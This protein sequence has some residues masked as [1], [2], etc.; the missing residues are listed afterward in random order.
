MNA[1]RA[2]VVGVGMIGSLHARIYAEDPRTSLAAVVDPDEERARRV[3]EPLGATWYS[4]TETMLARETVDLVSIAT[5]EQDRF[6]PAIACARAGK[7]LL[8]EKPLAPTL[9]E[10]KRLVA[11]IEATDVRTT[12]NFT[13]RSDPRYQRARAAMLDGTIGE[14]CTFFARRR[15]TNA[16]VETYAPWTDLLISTAIHDID[17]MVWING[18]PVVR[19][20]AEAV[21]KRSSEWGRE[22]AVMALLRFANGAVGSL[23][24]SWVLPSTVPAPL[25]AVLH[26]VG[27]GGGVFIEGSNHGLAVADQEG[28]RHPDL[29]HWP[30]GPRGVF[31]DLQAHVAGFIGDVL[32]GAPTTVTMQDALYAQEIV[33]AMK[34][35]FRCGQPV[36]FPFTGEE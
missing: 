36:T 4:D 20:F 10:A 11:A 22:D 13:L 32:C 33:A 35:S 25:D 29:T 30:V 24:T 9:R 7:H 31:G 28:Y 26:V 1:L 27:T 5:R 19:V 14:P 12:V 3:A 16:G 34:A 21:V 8:L 23:E 18:S 15:G 2:A 6:A 17:A